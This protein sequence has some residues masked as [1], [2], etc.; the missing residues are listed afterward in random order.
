MNPVLGGAGE[1]ESTAFVALVRRLGRGDELRFATHGEHMRGLR[2]AL[3]RAFE[4]E[5]PLGSLTRAWVVKWLR[6]A[7]RTADIGQLSG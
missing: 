4:L 3:C 6:A 2:F 5:A 7:E 1:Q